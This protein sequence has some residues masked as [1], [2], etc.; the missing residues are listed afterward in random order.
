[1]KLAHAGARRRDFFWGSIRFGVFSVSTASSH[2]SSAL[3]VTAD[4]DTAR[5]VVLKHSVARANGRRKKSTSANSKFAV[6]TPEG[7]P[8]IALDWCR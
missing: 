8:N 4:S 7:R 5:A 3:T 2:A 6:L 1:M